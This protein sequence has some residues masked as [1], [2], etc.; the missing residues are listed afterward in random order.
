VFTLLFGPSDDY[1][2]ISLGDG[3]GANDAG[4]G[5]VDDW[6]DDNAG[7]NGQDVEQNLLG[8]I[9]GI[10]VDGGAPYDIRRQPVRGR[11][12]PRRD[13]GLRVPQSVPL[14]VRPRRQPRPHRRRRRP[15]AL[16]GGQRRRQGGQL[17]LEREGGHA[18]LQ[19]G[20]TESVAGGVPGRR[21]VWAAGEY[22]YRGS[23]LP[24][25]LGRYVFG[26]WSESFGGPPTGKL[27]VAKSRKRG[28]WQME[29]LRI[30]TSPTGELGHRVLGFGQDG[31]GELYVLTTDTLARP[32][33][34]G[35]VFKLVSPNGKAG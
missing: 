34:T 16:G 24:Q 21:R 33:R 20:H 28:L 1:L 27:F 35:K 23:A 29:Q 15:A 26:D 8:N 13:L 30:A 17:R 11:A 22:V 7:G 32:A 19:H 4:L 6:Y 2:Y 9:L 31:A 12:G 10:D 25:F 3:G 5:H 18:L 14:L